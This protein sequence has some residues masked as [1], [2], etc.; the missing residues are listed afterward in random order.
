[1]RVD[2]GVYSGWEVPFHYDPILSKLIVW[3][4]N[5]EAAIKRMTSALS[6]YTILGIKTTISFLRDVVQH[7]EFAAGNT[8]T[9]FIPSYMDGWKDSKE[10][11]CEQAFIAAAMGVLNKKHNKS[12]ISKS[13]EQHDDPWDTIGSWQIGE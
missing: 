12:K 13:A 1:V 6:E 2:T 4:E 3:G 9:N 8:Y 10:K 5:R 11:Y 7:P